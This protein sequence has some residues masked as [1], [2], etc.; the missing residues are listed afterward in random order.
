[1]QPARVS[2]KLQSS[3][4]FHRRLVNKEEEMVNRYRF[5]ATNAEVVFH[6]APF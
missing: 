1:L 4:L 2:C 3:D 6:V 5:M